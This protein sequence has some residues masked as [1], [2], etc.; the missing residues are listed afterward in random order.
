MYIYKYT[1]LRNRWRGIDPTTMYLYI[2]NNTHPGDVIWV[3][4]YTWGV[5]SSY[6]YIIDISSYIVYNIYYIVDTR[7]TG[8]LGI[9]IC[10]IIMCIECVWLFECGVYLYSI[11]RTGKCI[12]KFVFIY[13]IISRNISKYVIILFGWSITTIYIM[14]ERK[15]TQNSIVA[16]VFVIAVRSD[17][18][19]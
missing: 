17:D 9:I 15:I 5:F 18:P 19:K 13:N 7:V 2:G 6:L 14:V 10:V 16:V 1:S 3:M 8:I 12:L 4:L 11:Q